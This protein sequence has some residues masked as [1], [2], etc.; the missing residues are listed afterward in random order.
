MGAIL[1]KEALMSR[2][3]ALEAFLSP[4]RRLRHVNR[5]RKANK[6]PLL[7]RG[8]DNNRAPLYQGGFR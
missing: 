7:N 4:L 8:I 1:L 5:G 6:G 3:K 2:K